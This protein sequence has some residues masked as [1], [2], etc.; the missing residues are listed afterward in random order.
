MERQ[1]CAF[2]SYRHSPLDAAV[3]E[4]LHK[5]I[6][7]F[8]VPKDLRKA[9]RKTL[10]L[11]FRDQEELYINSNLSDAL[12]QAL[13][14]SQFLIVVCTPETPKSQWVDQ[15]IRYF[16]Q[17]H[18]RE[19]VLAVL[20]AGTPEES[21]PKAITQIYS[22]DVET[23]IE[24]IE[25]LCAYLVDESDQKVLRNL[26]K[27]FPRL[28]A[29]ILGCPY[30]ALIQRQKRYRTQQIAVGIGALAVIAMLFIGLLIN[31]NLQI[32]AKNQEIEEKNQQVAQQLLQT[33][34]N[35]TKA[36]TLLSQQ[37]MEDGDRFSALENALNALPHDND[38]RPYSPEAEFALTNALLPYQN[39]SLNHHFDIELPSEVYML[40]VS[41]DG[42]YLATFDRR[43]CIRCFE[44]ET[45]KELWQFSIP[46]EEKDFQFIYSV[47]FTLNIVD[48]CSIVLLSS[49][50]SLY[51]LSLEDGTL[52]HHIDEPI[53][54]FS[55]SPDGTLF[56]RYSEGYFLICDTSSFEIIQEIEFDGNLSHNLDICQP[57]FSPDGSQFAFLI[58][59]REPAAFLL[60]T[61]DVAT[62]RTR[63]V[64]LFEPTQAL[65]SPYGARLDLIY[66]P[67]GSWL[68]YW[69]DEGESYGSYYANL[70]RVSGDGAQ[71]DSFRIPLDE[72]DPDEVIGHQ[73]IGS[74]L[75]LIH[76]R[77]VL[78]IDWKT[79][80]YVSDCV[81]SSYLFTKKDTYGSEIY[82]SYYL[83][84]NNELV[85]LMGDTTVQLLNHRAG[86]LDAYTYPYPDL[87]TSGGVA[88]SSAN[89]VE[90]VCFVS[91]STGSIG[92]KVS[93]YRSVPNPNAATIPIEKMEDECNS[94]QTIC[95]PSGTFFLTSRTR[96]DGSN[97]P[98]THLFTVYDTAT[99]EVKD[100]FSFTDR[101]GSA[102]VL[103]FSADER[104]LI[105]DRF[106]YDMATHTL[107]EFAVPE[108][109]ADV[110]QSSLNGQCTDAQASGETF[111]CAGFSMD[112][113]SVVW[114][115]DGQNPQSAE[116]PFALSSYEPTVKVGA[117]GLLVVYNIDDSGSS[118]PMPPSTTEFFIYSI[119]DGTWT[120]LP[121]NSSVASL[122]DLA[123]CSTKKQ[124][125]VASNNNSTLQLYDFDRDAIVANWPL[126]VPLEDIHSMEFIA[127][128]RFLLI[129]SINGCLTAI[130]TADGS[131][132]AEILTDG[133]AYSLYNEFQVDP[134]TNSLYFHSDNLKGAGLK[135]DLDSW[136][137]TAD[138]PYFR[139]YIPTADRIVQTDFYNN[140]LLITPVF[141]W[142]AL[143][144]QG[145]L[146][147]NAVKAGRQSVS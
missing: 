3:A 100:T 63:S 13:D 33:Q 41:D 109:K 137:V 45:T 61:H 121:G 39:G 47:P 103:G 18:G 12:C 66:L 82:T 57:V 81:L 120:R 71:E 101:T 8:P 139:S 43:G 131:V 69:I 72:A 88:V 27:E 7:R 60:I 2:I 97:G 58:Y 136:T 124:L 95:A 130:D 104:I 67:D 54:L 49:Y 134:S 107:S 68:I 21:I 129:M 141:T 125:V 70:F 143:M 76:P 86:W 36:L 32:T 24:E 15:E 64:S 96:D 40:D 35:E 108:G 119:A 106:Y 84:T 4:Q 23:V 75:L 122:S 46:Q 62:G 99:L 73:V 17:T 38:H 110:L 9:D 10:G 74:D 52:Q 34:I 118:G 56:S 90:T 22:P 147:L 19:R 28:A 78:T 1:Y 11:A 116:L 102:H 30:D 91:N 138:I 145:S 14:H 51:G 37:Q 113:N 5:M 53:E 135:I 111:L 25:P 29:A 98:Y 59:Q 92:N 112:T 31:R 44:T 42:R 123:I 85:L 140:N 146:L 133:P 6:E 89:G 142:E 117:S 87:S 65:S 16:I 132:K 105:F 77:F 126:P 114:W 94:L 20:A 144:E 80:S 55:L 83:N 115:T 26:K 48:S 93:I 127:Q 128:D 79:C 50:D